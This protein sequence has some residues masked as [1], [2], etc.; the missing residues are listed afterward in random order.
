MGLGDVQALMEAIEYCVGHGGDI[1]AE[2][3]LE[4]YESKV[5]AANGRMLGVADKLHW[6]YS[7]QGALGVGVRSLGLNAVNKMEWLKAFF[8]RQAGGVDSAVF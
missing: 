2:A 1:G 7:M 8:M 3:N 4:R 5:Y 6:L